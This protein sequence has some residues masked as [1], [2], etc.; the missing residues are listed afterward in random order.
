MRER[1]DVM[2]SFL[3]GEVSLLVSTGV[4]GRGVDLLVVRQVIVFDMPNTIKEY[5]H[6]IGRA[7]RMGDQ[8]SAILFV[9]EESRNLFPDLVVALK[10]CGA[11]IPKQL[12][13]LTSAREMH[14]NKKRRVGY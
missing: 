5:I 14:S 4:L 1:R 8:G 7:S 3:G 6:V 11:A 9:N 12:T 13:S 10:S 2:G